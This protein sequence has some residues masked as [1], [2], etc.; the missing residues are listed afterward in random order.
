GSE[1]GKAA[2]DGLGDLRRRATR[3]SVA[4]RYMTR[5]KAEPKSDASLIGATLG[6]AKETSAPGAG[7]EALALVGDQESRAL[8]NAAARL[9]RHCSSL[10]NH[11]VSL[12]AATSTRVVNS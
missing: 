8:S 10:V 6:E 5:W 4:I 9:P 2:A 7:F 3:S 12:S 1:R 11:E